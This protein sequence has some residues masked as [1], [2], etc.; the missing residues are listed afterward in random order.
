MTQADDLAGYFARIDFRLA[1]L[2][3]LIVVAVALAANR[4]LQAA[5]DD[6]L[7]ALVQL[8][9]GIGRG[10]LGRRPEPPRPAWFCVTCRSV[11][12]AAAEACYRGCG[13][14]ATQDAGSFGPLDSDGLPVVPGPFADQSGPRS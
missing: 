9:R 7:G 4:F 8:G 1:L 10:L 14:R 13:P 11:N 5:F 12:A 6:V 2:V 3:A